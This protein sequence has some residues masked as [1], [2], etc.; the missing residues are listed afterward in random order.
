MYSGKAHPL[1]HA[2]EAGYVPENDGVIIPSQG[3]DRQQLEIHFTTII[4]TRSHVVGIAGGQSW[5]R[6]T[7][8]ILPLGGM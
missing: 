1:H 8:G 3:K 4:T 2:Q 5:E 7:T 6:C